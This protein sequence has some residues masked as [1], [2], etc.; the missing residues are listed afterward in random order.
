MKFFAALVIITLVVLSCNNVHQP[1]RTLLNNTDSIAINYFTGD[2]KMDSVTAVCIIKDKETIENIIQQATASIFTKKKTC[3]YDGSLHFFK[4]NRVVL[5]M[6]FKKI[7]PTCNAFEFTYDG[8][9]VHTTLTSEMAT[10][11]HSFKKK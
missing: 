2:G 11:L 10:M 8:K 9:L 7:D 6:W 3:G 4:S 5:D 1:T